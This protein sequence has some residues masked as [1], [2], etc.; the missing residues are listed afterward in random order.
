VAP[1]KKTW[2]WIIVTIV[3]LCIASVLAIAAFG[4]YFVS[5]HISTAKLTGAEADKR[6]DDVR[7][8]F[9]DQHPLLEIDTMGQPRPVRPLH[10]LP[11]SPVKP[12]SLSILAWNPREGRM[13]KISLPFWIMRLGRKK[14]DIS[15]GDHRFDFDDLDLD[16]REL[17]RIGPA[18]VID[19]TRPTG[20]RVLVWTQ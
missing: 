9:K 3:G 20:E 11:A 14:I 15:S 4:M 5:Q 12:E 16:V 6:F 19:L 1:S 8:T 10:E 13:A 18:I 17:E 2:I 7:A